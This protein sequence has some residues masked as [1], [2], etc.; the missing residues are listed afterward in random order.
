MADYDARLFFDPLDTDEPWVAGQGISWQLLRSVEAEDLGGGASVPVVE[1]SLTVIPQSLPDP[2]P[3]ILMF[4]W[5]GG[6]TVSSNFQV[7]VL[8]MST[9]S[10]ERRLLADRPT[11]RMTVRHTGLSRAE[12]TKIVMN[13][14]RHGNERVPIPLYSDHSRITATSAIKEIFCETQYRRF[15]AGQRFIICDFDS[16]SRPT[17]VEWG[18]IDNVAATHIVPTI[19]LAGSYGIGARVYPMIDV[20]I[21]FRDEA[22]LFNDEKGELKISVKEIP[23]QSALPPT[24]SGTPTGFVEYDD[25]PIF[26]ETPDANF[27]YAP[28]MLRGGTQTHQGRGNVTYV[29]GAR[30]QATHSLTYRALSRAS[31][32]PRIQF[33]DSRRG[34]TRAFWFISPESMWSATAIAAGS[35]TIVGDGNIED[36]EDFHSHVAILERD[37]TIH[38]RAISN[39]VLASGDFRIDFDE[40]LDTTPNL[41]DIRRVTPAYKMRFE[42]N[43]MT[44]E[45]TTDG[46]C[47]IQFE[48]VELLREIEITTLCLQ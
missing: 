7:D 25:L 46:K 32:W 5:A 48:M 1:S 36:I 20:E 38:I 42:K 17:N 10:E 39:V 6:I 29:M 16:N 34:R 30:P 19:A 40:N 31:A 24:A 33:F 3:N 35:V 37:G 12:M 14:F 8:R 21:V 13:L 2:L 22:R 43:G 45:W 28:G 23:G 26:N 4:N 18:V 47:D 41:A 15:F 9:A 44:E 27:G 11:R